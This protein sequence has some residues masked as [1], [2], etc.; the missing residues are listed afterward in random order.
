MTLKQFRDKTKDLPDET[1]LAVF[2]HDAPLDYAVL[3]WLSGPGQQSDTDDGKL[4]IV[5]S[6]N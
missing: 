4:A 3:V 2:V 5:I 1:P 6:G